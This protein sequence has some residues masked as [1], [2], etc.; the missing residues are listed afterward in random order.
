MSHMHLHRIRTRL[1][2][3][4]SGI[5]IT[6]NQ[7]VYLLGWHL[8]GHITPACRGNGRGRLQWSTCIFRIALGAGILQL[9]R[10]F[11]SIP[12]TGI[13]NSTQAGNG[14][15][16]IKARLQ[17]TALRTAMHHRSLDGYQAEAPSCSRLIVGARLIG[18]TPIGVGKIV[19][20]WR[21]NKTIRHF[22]RTDLD[23]RIETAVR[24]K[25]LLHFRS[26]ARP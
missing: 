3:T 8:F 25:I 5:P 20:H 12:M 14:I 22:H 13:D 2:G 1:K 7:L 16:A 26:Q 19:S 24:H 4:F 21:N 9:H 23:R 11:G 18:P 17:G 15:V 6:P 10:D